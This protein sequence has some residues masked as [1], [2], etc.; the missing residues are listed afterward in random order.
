MKKPIT[1]SEYLTIRVARKSEPAASKEERKQVWNSLEAAKLIASL[2]TPMLVAWLGLQVKAADEA[3]ATQQAV[4]DR[5]IAADK[6]KADQKRADELRAADLAR[7]SELRKQDQSRADEQRKSEE[8]RIERARIEELGRERRVEYEIRYKEQQS[9]LADFTDL[10][11]RR[12]LILEQLAQMAPRDDRALPSLLSDGKSKVDEY[13]K[14]G[15]EFD[16]G[17]RNQL[18]KFRRILPDETYKLLEIASVDGFYHSAYRP[19]G[20]CLSQS[21]VESQKMLSEDAERMV[22]I[23]PIFWATGVSRR[24]VSEISDGLYS[25]MAEE[26]VKKRTPDK[27]TVEDYQTEPFHS[28]NRLIRERERLGGF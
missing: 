5:N 3:R 1:G 16:I 21:I 8:G 23:P 28:C 10:L 18:L 20:K 2:A 24:C 26:D 6:T 12:Q 25:A 4:N 11:L 17:V 27:L 15:E 22:C 9:A 14:L 7:A 19:A 13:K